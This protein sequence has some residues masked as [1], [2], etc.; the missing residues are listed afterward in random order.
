MTWLCYTVKKFT[1][2]FNLRV[3]K[4]LTLDKYVDDVPD[5]INN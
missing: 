3:G 4:N 1:T 5:T 2:L